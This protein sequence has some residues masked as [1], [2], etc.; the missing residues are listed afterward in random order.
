MSENVIRIIATGLILSMLMILPSASAHT[1]AEVEPYKIE[2]GWETEPPVVGIRNDLVLKITEAGETV[3]VY[4]GVTNVFKNLEATIRFG[5]ITKEL[6]INSDVRPGYYF[7]P[8]IP[9]KTGTYFLDLKGDINNIA[10]NVQ[11]PIEDVEGTSI[12]DFP[13]VGG[14]SSGSEIIALKNAISSIQRDVSELES[15]GNEVS[16]D[17]KE[18]G[19]NAYDFALLAI[20]IGSSGIMLSIIAMLKR[21]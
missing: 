19:G 2:I 12:L 21:K 5:G 14:G 10:V 1:T 13:S 20:G 9:T 8:V 18:N 6:D 3:G 7:S 11:M 16:L 15:G 4:K 17:K